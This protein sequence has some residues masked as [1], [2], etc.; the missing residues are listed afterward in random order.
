MPILHGQTW[1]CSAY[2]QN[3]SKT[4]PFCT[5]RCVHHAILPEKNTEVQ[6]QQQPGSLPAHVCRS[7]ASTIDMPR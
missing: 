1:W 7:Q 3:T 6:V 4:P 2:C 5:K